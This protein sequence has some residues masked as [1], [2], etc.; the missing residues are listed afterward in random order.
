[1]AAPEAPAEGMPFGGLSAHYYRRGSQGEVFFAGR[2]PGTDL[3]IVFP[4]LENGDVSR[5]AHLYD[6]P[7]SSDLVDV[8]SP[9]D[10]GMP[11]AKIRWAE[12]VPD[13]EDDQP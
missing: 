8:V 6:I 12:E 11:D 13:Q 4:V 9:S 5:R 3:I 1:M 10:L 2:R 7:Y